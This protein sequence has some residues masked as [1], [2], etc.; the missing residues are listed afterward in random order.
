M[1]KTLEDIIIERIQADGPMSVGDYMSLALGHPEHGYYMKQD[2]FGRAGDFVTA[3]EVSQLFG[4]MIGVW[5]AD[6]WKQMGAPKEFVLLECGPGRGT[7][8][9][10]ILRATK[11]IEGFHEAARLHLLEISPVLKK[12]QA[13]ALK[14]HD[15][16]WHKGVSSVP[17]DAPMI[18]M[19]NEFLD[20][21]PFQQFVGGEERK[22]DIQGDDLAFTLQGEVQEHAP[23][24]ENFVREICAR[25]IAQKGA[26]LFID[27]G[28]VKSGVGDTFQAIKG[29]EYVDVF[30]HIGDADLTS[31][32]D[33]EA[34]Q[35]NVQAQVHGPVEQGA[36]L[37][38]LGI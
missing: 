20:A 31:H 24:R 26:A 16:V 35:E 17:D 6:I 36:F 30:S 14:A 33:F 3:P 13:D 9:A 25:I 19:G 37:K 11:G 8:M 1:P 29:H 21:L 34:L 4:E 12:M 28:H 23:V 15:P 27:Y 32:V 10:D 7:L 38:A 2:P 5:V 18:V 22:I